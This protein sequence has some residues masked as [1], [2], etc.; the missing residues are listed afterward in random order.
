MNGLTWHDGD[1]IVTCSLEHGAV[2]I[3]SH[4]QGLRH[5]V[6]VKVLTLFPTNLEIQFST[7]FR[8]L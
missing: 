7:R 8:E 4:F 5:G 1:E 3:P 2:L 6:D